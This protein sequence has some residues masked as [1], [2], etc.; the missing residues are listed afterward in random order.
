[1]K[2]QTIA[3]NISLDNDQL[4]PV[5]SDSQPDIKVAK[6]PRDKKED[7]F[8]RKE[9]DKR[10]QLSGDVKNLLKAVLGQ[11]VFNRGDRPIRLMD[12]KEDRT[13]GENSN[14]EDI[15]S[16]EDFLEEKNNKKNTMEKEKESLP[17]G[18]TIKEQLMAKKDAIEKVIIPGNPEGLM[19]SQV[20]QGVGELVIEKAG[21]PKLEKKDAQQVVA[22][23]SKEDRVKIVDVAG[24]QRKVADERVAELGRKLAVAY[25]RSKSPKQEHD[26]T[27]PIKDEIFDVIQEQ[28][29]G[30]MKKN[31]KDGEDRVRGEVVKT[32]EKSKEQVQGEEKEKKEKLESLK[33]KLEETFKTVYEDYTNKGKEVPV[34]ILKL[35]SDTKQDLFNVWPAWQKGGK[36][37]QS[38]LGNF[39][40]ETKVKYRKDDKSKE[41]RVE[42]KKKATDNAGAEEKET[43]NGALTQAE[44]DILWKGITNESSDL[45]RSIFWEASRK[46]DRLADE[47]LLRRAE[48]EKKEGRAKVT[49]AAEVAKKK[50]LPKTDPMVAVIDQSAVISEPAE[51][52]APVEKKIKPA[53]ISTG[54]V[55]LAEKSKIVTDSFSSSARNENQQEESKKFR[56]ELERQKE[57]KSRFDNIQEHIKKGKAIKAADA[58]FALDYTTREQKRIAEAEK[59][60]AARAETGTEKEKEKEKKDKKEIEKMLEPKKME[61]FRKFGQDFYTKLKENASWEGYNKE[62]KFRTLEIQ[63]RV[64]LSNQLK[65]RNLVGDNE[66]ADVVDFLIKKINK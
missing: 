63:T 57:E 58:V 2:E 4:G 3:E 59:K 45:E 36:G 28:N 32:I 29:P 33:T 60:I 61:I 20:E 18:H 55:K 48:A 47:E 64:F 15:S 62:D 40:E 6:K 21:E 41:K 9:A 37:K 8:F 34:E 16:K 46:S 10:E 53:P 65:R 22:A 26:L 5:S 14:N 54:P 25:K 12:D 13:H 27:K 52:P 19:S 43:R 56:E 38:S 35:L 39:I 66:I 51:K 30:W 17:S 1:M 50:D 49:G 24:N 7:H 44:V 23:K 42:N 11:D 31:K